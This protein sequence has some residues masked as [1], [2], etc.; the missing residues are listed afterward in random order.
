MNLGEIETQV[1]ALD[2]TLGFEL[3]Y[4]LFEAYGLPKASINRLKKGSLNKAQNGHELLWRGK[5]YYRLAGDNEDIY[6][7]VDSAKEDATVLKQRPRFLIVRNS[8]QLVAIDAKTNDTLDIALSDLKTHV[9]FFLPWAG[10]EKTQLETLNY[11]DVKAAGKMAR[12]YDEV[13]KLNPVEDEH[14]VHRLN[15]FF[16]RLLFCFFAEDTGVFPKGVFTTSVASL[17][18]E[19]G[20]DLGPTLDSLFAVLNT[21][22]SKRKGVPSH[23]ADFGYVNGKLFDQPTPSPAFSRKARQILLECGTL[24]WS[25]INPDIFGSMIQ[26]VVHPGQRAAYGMHYTSVENIMKVIRPLF[27]DEL[28]QGYEDAVDSVRKLQNL[29]KRISSMRVFDPAC[30]SGNFLVVSYKELRKLEHRILQRI[31]DLR[32]GQVRFEYSGIK[33]ANFFGIEIDDFAHEIAILSLWLAKHQMNVEFHQMFGVGIALIPLRDT[34]S[35][36]NDDAVICEW[37]HVCPPSRDETYLLSNP[38]Y[39]GARLQTEEQKRQLHSV[40]GL[41]HVSGNL[42][43]VAAWFMKGARYV[44]AH[45]AALGFVSTNSICQ[46]EQVSLLWPGIYGAG[47]DISFAVQPFKWSNSAKGAA[48]VTCAVVGLERKSASPKV[49]YLGELRR[50]TPAISPYQPE[51]LERLCYPGD[52]R[53]PVDVR[54]PAD[55]HESRRVLGG[56][57]RRY[58]SARHR[59]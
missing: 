7:L 54:H 50:T 2:T 42:D 14:D 35:V 41:E 55:C 20:N 8:S 31:I 58:P 6:L 13:V 49:L 43:Y 28:E 46:G 47:A 45:D 57:R 21:E 36:V 52:S 3:I 16:S 23:F 40:P 56:N 32:G 30:G 25:Q 29:H 9:A 59:R 5:A 34:G 19:S 53:P 18:V 39:I 12:L 17:T 33:L 51:N 44:V 38:P 4:D 27:L 11:A 1:A 24:D 22:E 15:V 10:I 37:E 48:G 26:A